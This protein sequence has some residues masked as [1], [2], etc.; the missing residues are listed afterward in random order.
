M[1]EFMSLAMHKSRKIGNFFTQNQP[2]IK[3]HN[4]F[5]PVWKAKCEQIIM[6]AKFSM[7]EDKPALDQ[8]L[9]FAKEIG[10]K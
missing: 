10:I 2:D 1:L 3:E 4:T 8:I 7:K 9:S 5:V 6:K